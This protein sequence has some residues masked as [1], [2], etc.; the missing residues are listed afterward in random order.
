[1]LKL[2]ASRINV[3]EPNLHKRWSRIISK[4]SR[5]SKINISKTRRHT[6]TIFEQCVVLAYLFVRLKFRKSE[7]LPQG[8]SNEQKSHNFLRSNFFLHSLSSW[9]EVNM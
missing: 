7:C 9:C 4:R 8:S 5:A 1:M 6:I 2:S 3:Y